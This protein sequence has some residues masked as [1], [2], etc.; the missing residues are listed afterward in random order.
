MRK[1]F[2]DKVYAR[3]NFVC[4]TKS[5]SRR[6]AVLTVSVQ[7]TAWHKG[8]SAILYS[9]REWKKNCIL[10][11]FVV[12]KFCWVGCCCC[13]RCCCSLFVQRNKSAQESSKNFYIQLWAY[14]KLKQRILFTFDYYGRRFCPFL[15]PFFLLL[16]P[17]DTFTC[18]FFK[19]T[20]QF[21]WFLGCKF[22]EFTPK[23][24]NGHKTHSYHLFNLSTMLAHKLNSNF[25]KWN[26][27]GGKKSGEKKKK[28]KK[29]KNSSIDGSG[30][31]CLL[32]KTTEKGWGAD[33][34]LV[35][36]IIFETNWKTEPATTT[37]E[38]GIQIWIL[39]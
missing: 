3:C 16:H 12:I 34:K 27:V 33:I 26:K 32:S 10:F 19:Y 6:S 30:K 17:K 22:D 36:S 39:I 35:H 1:E 7:R 20:R 4:Q 23:K 13:C 31:R 2:F 24:W 29:R 14:C 25:A 8:R 15:T 9:K 38:K 21:I 5:V 37:T 18:N 28:K 11:P